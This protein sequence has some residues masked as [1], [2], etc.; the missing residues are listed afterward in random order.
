V[1]LTNLMLRQLRKSV[2]VPAI[3][4]LAP[5]AHP[6]VP[7]GKRVPVID[8]R[9]GSVPPRASGPRLRTP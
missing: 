8:A 5:R 9:P 2:L 6:R 1:Q 7:R 4:E 3:T